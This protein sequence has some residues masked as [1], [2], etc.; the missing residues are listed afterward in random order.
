IGRV[1]LRK[2][3]TF[4]ERRRA[5]AQRYLAAFSGLDFLRV[6]PS[7]EDHAWHLF[8]IRLELQKLSI[9]RDRFIELLQQRG[10]G[11]SVHFIPLHMMSYYRDRYGLKPEDFPQ[12]LKT[13]QSCISLPLSASHTVE[14]IERVIEAVAEVGEGN[15]L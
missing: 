11:V 8:I 3:Q 9:G 2:A 4:L 14:E 10:I 6:P 13:Y 1:Q 5:V 12:T 15:H 7:A